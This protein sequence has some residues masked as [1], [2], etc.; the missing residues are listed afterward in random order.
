[1]NGSWMNDNLEKNQRG[2]ATV[3]QPTTWNYV[4]CHY[5]MALSHTSYVIKVL[6][7]K[8]KKKKNL[9]PIYFGL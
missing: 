9:N 1:M 5:F 8:K 7:L 3:P 6:Y 4:N 2:T